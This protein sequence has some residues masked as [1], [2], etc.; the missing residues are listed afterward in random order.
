MKD[1]I[2]AELR[3]IRDE[4]AASFNYDLD[5]VVADLRRKE[6]SASAKIVSKRPRR[7]VKR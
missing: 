4:H 7:I 5:A 6:K 2:I 1:T 3:K